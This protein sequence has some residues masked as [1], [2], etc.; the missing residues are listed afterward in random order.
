MSVPGLNPFVPP[1][2]A[3]APVPPQ[4]Q[5]PRP[6][7]P[8]LRNRPA[9]HN[10]QAE[11]DT[12]SGSGLKRGRPSEA[13]EEGMDT[14]SSSEPHLKRRRGEGEAATPERLQAPVGNIAPRDG[15]IREAQE[16][17]DTV[18]ATSSG[19]RMNPLSYA[20]SRGFESVVRYL[21]DSANYLNVN[22]AF[23]HAIKSGHLNIVELLHARGANPGVKNTSGKGCLHY[24][25]ESRNL[26]VLEWLLKKSAHVDASTTFGVTPLMQA[27][28][29]G[30]V[31]A[32]RML[33][34]HHANLAARDTSGRSCVHY[35]VES[36]DVSVMRWLLEHGAEVNV[37]ESTGLM[38][39]MQACG[40]GNIEVARLLQ[41]HHANLAAKDDRGRNCM[42]Y[43]AAHGRQAVV[44]WLLAQGAPAD[45]PDSQ[46]E[47]PIYCAFSKR[48]WAVVNSLLAA[49]VE[50]SRK[51][52]KHRRFAENNDKKINFAKAIFDGA[53]K[54][55][56]YQ[57]LLSLY[58]KDSQIFNYYKPQSLKLKN[59]PAYLK[60]LIEDKSYDEYVSSDSC[61]DQTRLQS[62]FRFFKNLGSDH[63]LNRGW[64]YKTS[65]L[66]D[67]EALAILHAE[68]RDLIRIFS[69]LDKSDSSA[70]FNWLSESKKSN[71]REFFYEYMD[72]IEKIYD[73]EPEEYWGSSES[74]SYK[75]DVYKTSQR[76]IFDPY[77]MRHPLFSY[78]VHHW[79]IPDHQAWML[80]TKALS[81]SKNHVYDV[82]KQNILLYKMK[83]LKASS[84]LKHIFSGKQLSSELEERLRADLLQKLDG[85]ILAMTESLVLESADFDER[86]TE[87]CEQSI[88]IRGY[89]HRDS[90]KVDL[91]KLFGI[92]E[93][94]ARR[95][96]ALVIHSMETVRSQ[97]MDL[98][99]M[100]SV[101]RA[102]SMSGLQIIERVLDNLK[103]SLIQLAKAHE[104]SDEARDLEVVDSVEED[105]YP[106]LSA[107][108]KNK[109]LSQPYDASKLP[110]F[111]DGLKKLEQEE[112]DL[113]ADLIFGQWRQISAALGVVLPDPF[114]SHQ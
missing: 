91:Q 102:L 109:P 78:V 99:P 85:M 95:L 71:R 70:A 88:D 39:L 63:I 92:Y 20:A 46:G 57:V 84:Q 54:D 87:L 68:V 48:H 8:T 35:A 76:P 83:A 21:V 73:I 105:S 55:S 77:F 61:D 93:V 43:A 29:R 42:Y 103:K 3:P 82:Q 101:D 6:G 25:V 65:S 33:H 111:K 66:Q 107:Q 81:G 41:A 62:Q 75:F 51:I 27:C 7:S 40:K 94:N 1:A 100:A 97:P 23:V 4:I 17:L 13:E 34:E 80:L 45:E 86:F 15:L 10:R 69:N 32:A 49:D 9:Q 37:P 112:Q 5:P 110:G 79:M 98:P 38:P 67:F 108:L 44:D 96:T 72:A 58:Q 11:E 114:A 56:Q 31:E 16:V 106:N 47:T 19:R 60:N 113:Y 50:L 2:P 89:F 28:G 59:Q 52:S 24:A 64:N 36:G 90:F 14:E 53:I 12:A 22:I 26:A 104:S 30:D 18:T 74:K